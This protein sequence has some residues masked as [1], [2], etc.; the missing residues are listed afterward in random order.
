VRAVAATIALAALTA[1]CGNP[2]KTGVCAAVEGAE[3]EAALGG[4]PQAQ[5]AAAANTTPQ[6]LCSWTAETSNGG[7]RLLALMVEKGAGK[8][9]F[10]SESQKL[11]R[12][13]NRVGAIA[14][15]GENALMG[16]G[17]DSTAEH[18]S[19]EIVALKGTDVL[20][21][22]IEGQDPAA[23]EALARAAAKAM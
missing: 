19:G 18:F 12:A 7:V 15:V 3:L 1:A 10:E 22:R 2:M 5:S 14:E 8:E 11:R 16:I 17:E 13:Y 20:S 23:F 6:T 21:M 4:K 9:H